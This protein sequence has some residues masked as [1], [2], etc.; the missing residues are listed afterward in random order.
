MAPPT[1]EPQGFAPT[2]GFERLRQRARIL[3]GIRAFFRSRDVLEV[4]TPVL[5]RGGVSDPNLEPF[6][7]ALALGSG[8]Q[9]LF[10]QTS[11]EVFM[12]RLLA[13]GSG[14]VFQLGKAFRNGEAGSR[15]NPEFTMLEWYRPGFSTDRLMDEV[16]DLVSE[17][18]G[19]P[20]PRRATYREIFLEHAGF[21]PFDTPVEAL[22][23]RA[24]RLGIRAPSGLR[25]DDPDPWHDLILCEAIEHR[26]GFDAPLFVT[27][28]PAH[29]ASLAATCPE[30]P[31]LSDRFELYVRGLELANGF[32]ELDDAREQERRFQDLNRRRAQEGLPGL[33]IDLRFLAALEAGLPPCSGVALGVDRL[34][35]LATGAESIAEVVAFPLEAL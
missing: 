27:R 7:T 18:L 20:R 9:P 2:A 31:R 8:R 33:P 35:M 26:L 21:D 1:P 16:G 23:E 6:E 30:D 34:V 17:V 5:G 29:R 19:T 15:H 3:E 14:P 4:E 13:A 28:Y 32:R 11:P 10:L 12:K 25:G 24:A 22:P